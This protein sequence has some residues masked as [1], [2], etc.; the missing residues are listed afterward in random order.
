MSLPKFAQDVT[1]VKHI[2]SQCRYESDYRQCNSKQKWNSNKCQGN[3]KNLEILEF[4][5]RSKCACE[6]DKNCETGAYLKEWRCTR[7]LFDDL[8]V[9]SDEIVDTPVTT[10]IIHKYRNNSISNSIFTIV[11]SYNCSVL[12]ERQIKISYLLSN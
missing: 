8:V 4:R 11:S 1:L 6:C 10:S 12:Y 5:N 7:S 2:S 3:C 9:T